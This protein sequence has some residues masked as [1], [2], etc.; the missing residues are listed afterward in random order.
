LKPV[1][2]DTNVIVP[3]LENNRHIIASIMVSHRSA[4]KKATPSGVVIMRDSQDLS[5]DTDRSIPLL[6]LSESLPKQQVKNESQ[7][8][9][10][11]G[12]KEI[13]VGGLES[14]AWND[15]TPYKEFNESLHISLRDQRLENL[16]LSSTGRSVSLLDRVSSKATGKLNKNQSSPVPIV[17]NNGLDVDSVSN[18]QRKRSLKFRPGRASAGE[19]E[20]F[21]RR[22]SVK[23]VT[24]KGQDRKVQ[25]RSL[26]GSREA[27]V[28]PQSQSL[29]NMYSRERKLKNPQYAT[30]TQ[31]VSLLQEAK[32]HG[33]NDLNE[34]SELKIKEVKSSPLIV[35]KRGEESSLELVFQSGLSLADWKSA[36]VSLSD[37]KPKRTLT[38][39]ETIDMKSATMRADSNTSI[40]R[41]NLLVLDDS[42][43]SNQYGYSRSQQDFFAPY[44]ESNKSR[45]MS[46]AELNSDPTNRSMTAMEDKETLI[47]APLPISSTTR[48]FAK[49]LWKSA[50]GTFIKKRTRTR[51]YERRDI[52]RMIKRLHM[53]R[54]NRNNYYRNFFNSSGRTN[55]WRNVLFLLVWT[56]I[57]LGLHTKYMDLGRKVF[58]VPATLDISSSIPDLMGIALG[59]L[60]Y[61][62]ACVSSRRWWRGRIEWQLLMEN[63]KRLTILLNTH[64]NSLHLSE[65][66]TRMIVAHT[67]SVWCFLQ[68][69]DCEVWHE[70]LTEILDK[71]TAQ[72][73]MINS[74]RLRPLSILYAFQRIVEICIRNRILPREVVRDINPILFALSNSFDACNRSRI[75]QFPWIMAVHL[76]FVVIIFLLTL[77]LTLVGDST[78]NVDGIYAV[79]GTHKATVS[80]IAVY[81]YVFLISYAYFGLYQMAV[82]IEDPFSYKRE[83]FSFGLWGLYEYWTA[84]EMSDVRHIFGFRVRKNDK[85]QISS[86]G[87]YGVNWPV[88]TIE[89]HIVKAIEKG[90]VKNPK[91][92][93]ALL[94]INRRDPAYWENFA[95][96][97]ILHEFTSS[98][99]LSS[100]SDDDFD[101][102]EK[103]DIDTFKQDTRQEEMCA[104]SANLAFSEDTLQTLKIDR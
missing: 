26:P 34:D 100:A 93:K 2:F 41:Q 83:S 40:V 78:Q 58:G 42:F 97:N 12:E 104:G 10:V 66:G 85:G 75:A 55:P 28:G 98:V 24:L 46:F 27:S 57:V 13:V 48:V 20:L 45:M 81:V 79:V 44:E 37:L 49:L 90:M 15:E 52:L 70:E 29:W 103:F 22:N 86:A 96:S 6:L 53:I 50:G 25:A 5:I 31:L 73:I 43:Q 101:E 76:N 11:R 68:D 84:I 87:S 88:E 89:P 39:S 77:P 71:R 32:I 51:R 74:R 8:N 4:P 3:G 47:S 7:A 94:N 64:L 54:N 18:W 65:F 23:L 33:E 72:R 63:N 95:K 99:S 14:H 9:I 16:R 69:K 21:I 35:R 56:T 30:S 92:V 82:D 19:T 62:Q 17:R 36:P 67:M 91:K 60:L 80:V 102:E 1:I 38:I 61:M 59:Y